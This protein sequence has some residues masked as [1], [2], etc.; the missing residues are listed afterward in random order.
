M[1]LRNSI[2]T[3]LL[4]LGTMRYHN[5]DSKL[6]YY[7]DVHNEIR[8]TDMGTPLSLFEQHLEVIGKEGFQV[9]PRIKKDEGEVALLFDDGFHGIYDVRQFFYDRSIC[10]TVFLA[11]SLI[12]QDGYLNKEE[13]IE[14]QQHG[15]IF[16]SHG[17]SHKDLTLCDD[18]S[19]HHELVDARQWLSDFLQKDVCELC[20]PLGCF[21]DRVVA[22]AQDAGYAT[23]Y[24]SVPGSYRQLIAGSLRPRNLLQFA[25]PRQVSHILR[26][27]N[28]MFRHRLEK[29]H[30][31]S[32]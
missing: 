9:V 28:E 30:F 11:V 18:Q 15:F 6:L 12:G 22:L 5:R 24:S 25:S 21:S 7:H 1:S 13:I 29:M 8:Y 14:L 19:L 20:L 26:G 27:G 31:R 10:P 2:K 32:E 17:W 16:E 23:I 4:W 3:G